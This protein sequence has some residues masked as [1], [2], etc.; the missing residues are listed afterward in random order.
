M[1]ASSLTLAA[2]QP[3]L[4]GSGALPWIEVFNEVNWGASRKAFFS[5]YEYAAMLS[6]AYDGHGGALGPGYGARTADPNIKVAMAGLGYVT[7]PAGVMLDYVKSI[8]YWAQSR[9]VSGDSCG[10]VVPV[11]VRHNL[12]AVLLQPNGD[13]PAHAINIHV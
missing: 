5:P 11:S 9:R 2:G 3:T 4:S 6:A 13:F 12:L 10:G 1:P 7:Y 8:H